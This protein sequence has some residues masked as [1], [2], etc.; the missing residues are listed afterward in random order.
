MRLQLPRLF[1]GD[2]QQGRSAAQSLRPRRQ[3][4]R[5]D[6]EDAARGAGESA[7]RVVQ[8]RRSPPPPPRRQSPRSP[9]DRATIRS[10]ATFLSRRLLNKSGSEKETWHIDFDLSG[11]GLD[12]VVGNSFGIFAQQRSRPCRSDHRPARRVAYHR[13]KGQDAA[14]G[15][16]IGRVAGARAGFAVRTDLLHHR[17]RAAREGARAGAGR[18][19]RRRCRDAGRDGGVAE[20]FRRAPASRSFCRGAGAAAAAALFD[21]VVAQCDAR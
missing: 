18:G 7:S 3:G 9:G 5:A 4:N 21:L 15:V 6:A 14:R 10:L 8:A 19:S 2:R 12:Y 1:R 13:S 11:C 17:R 16:D 20:I